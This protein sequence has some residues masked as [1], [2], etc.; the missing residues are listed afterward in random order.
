M[1]QSSQRIFWTSEKVDQELKQI[2]INITKNRC[3]LK[4]I[5]DEGEKIFEKY[6]SQE[7]LEK[8]FEKIMISLNKSW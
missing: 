8:E 5:G 4:K 6:F 2:M 7:R 1:A 3:L